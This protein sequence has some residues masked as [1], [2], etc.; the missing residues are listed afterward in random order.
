MDTTLA[1]SAADVVAHAAAWATA[2]GSFA[3][4]Q[5]QGGFV[6]LQQSFVQ[7]YA[8]VVNQPMA[9]HVEITGANPGDAH[10]S[11]GALVL[12]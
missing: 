3:D 12:S 11:F 10:V 2:Q 7:Y 9:F 1:P 4:L 6:A 8:D 5:T